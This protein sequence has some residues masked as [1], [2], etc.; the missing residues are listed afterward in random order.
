M[1]QSARW[2]G[3]QF[4]LAERNDTEHSL[5]FLCTPLAEAEDGFYM[6][7]AGQSP[8]PCSTIE[9]VATSPTVKTPSRGGQRGRNSVGGRGGRQMPRPNAMVHGGWQEGRGSAIGPQVKILR[10][11]FA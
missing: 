11:P 6:P 1:Y 5:D 8:R 4:Q 10:V 9:P 3:W 2:G 7:I